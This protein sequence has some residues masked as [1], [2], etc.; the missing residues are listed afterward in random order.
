M[1][2]VCGKHIIAELVKPGTFF[3][4][5]CQGKPE[6]GKLLINTVAKIVEAWEPPQL[7][8]L[9]DELISGWI[10]QL[11]FRSVVELYQ[12]F[13]ASKREAHAMAIGG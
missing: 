4:L 10:D 3:W 11:K 13:G 8:D 7:D 9:T 2:L 1:R 6:N 5:L 12:V